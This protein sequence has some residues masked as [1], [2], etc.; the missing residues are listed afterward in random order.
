MKTAEL[1]GLKVAVIGG[2]FGGAAATVFLDKLGVDV[3]LYE[4]A[5]A[6]REVGAGIGMRPPTVE[7]FRRWGIFDAMASVSSASDYFE[8]LT[9]RGEVVLREEWPKTHEYEQQNKTRLIHR[10]DFIDTFVEHIPADRLHLGHKVV[11]IQDHGHRSTVTF[12][13][14]GKETADLVVGAEGIRSAVRAQLFADVEPVFAHAHAHRAVIS[15]DDTYGL[16]ADDNFRMYQ[17]DNGSLVYFLPLRHRDQVSFDITAPSDDDS[18]RPE[19]TVD[20]IAGLLTGFDERLQKIARNLN[21]AA[22]TSRGVYDIDSLDRWHTDSVVLIGDAAHA[23]L[24]HQGQGANQTIQDSSALA[25]ALQEA[26]SVKNALAL[27]ESRRKPTTDA[28]QHVSRQEWDS[29]EGLKTAF[30]EKES[31]D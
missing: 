4:Q 28:L 15:A 11:S 19:V 16:V 10:S 2:G 31:I 3:H 29:K 9:G 21:P 17:G 8:I 22:V 5:T 13:D 7:V 20:E 25:E 27:Y 23:M 24:H 12:E 30:P 18:W 26:D 1:E 6:I 14:G